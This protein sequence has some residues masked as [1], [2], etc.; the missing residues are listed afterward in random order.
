MTLGHAAS[1]STFMH[2]GECEMNDKQ[3]LNRRFGTIAWGLILLLIGVLSLIPGGQDGI[4]VL[5][6]G[7]ILIGLNLARRQSQ[8]PISGTTLLLGL[9]TLVLGTVAMLRPWLNLAPF[10]LPLIPTA[11]IFVAVLLLA[12]AVRRPEVGST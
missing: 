7:L 11:M 3:A 2:T 10:E 9:L 4:L 5:G 12:R 8:I 6:V 1:T